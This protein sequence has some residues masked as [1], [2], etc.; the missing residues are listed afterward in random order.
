LSLLQTGSTFYL[1]SIDVAGTRTITATFVAAANATKGSYLIQYNLTYTSDT[2]YS[3]SSE[4]TFGLLLWG[5]PA[6]KIN[7]LVVD[8]ST[9]NRNTLGV[10][11]V[12][13]VNAGTDPAK[14]LIVRI[15]ET[16]LLTS[17]TVYAGEVAPG[18]VTSITF[19][20][21]VPST[22]A[23]GFHMANITIS[24]LDSSGNSFV[25]SKMFGFQVAPQPGG[26]PT[27]DFA[28]GALSAVLIVLAFFSL[29]R[30]GVKL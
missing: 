30:L 16:D 6:I 27:Y 14:N 26:L 13:L 3:Y 12:E 8:P 2:G 24:Y 20:I 15:Y 4:A 19:G 1:G 7:N 5:A 28:L 29:R 11:T 18:G 22:E 25:E 17:T 9:L 23:L 10:L 21:H